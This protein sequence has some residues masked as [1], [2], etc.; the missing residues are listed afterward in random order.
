VRTESDKIVT[1]YGSER[2]TSHKHTKRK[3]GM[4][5]H[6]GMGQTDNNWGH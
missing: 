1:D 5:D 2:I 4:N 6:L 3:V